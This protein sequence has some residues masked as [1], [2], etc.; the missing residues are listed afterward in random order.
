MGLAPKN[1]STFYR[2]INRYK[3]DYD[4]DENFKNTIDILKAIEKRRNN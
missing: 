1:K 3:E 4:I 2:L